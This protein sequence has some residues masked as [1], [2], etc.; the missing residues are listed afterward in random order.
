MPINAPMSDSAIDEMFASIGRAKENVARGME[1][2]RIRQR[3]EARRRR[4]SGKEDI[5]DDADLDEMERRIDEELR[6]HQ[7]NLKHGK[8]SAITAAAT[9]SAGFD[10]VPDDIINDAAKVSSEVMGKGEELAK[11][12]EQDVSVEDIEAM[13][14]AEV[15][16][17]VHD[18][19]SNKRQPE[20]EGEEEK[21]DE[22]ATRPEEPVFDVELVEDEPTPKGEPEKESKMKQAEKAE[23]DDTIAVEFDDADEGAEVKDKESVA[24]EAKGYLL[25][26]ANGGM[27]GYAY[28]LTVDDSLS[29]NALHSQAVGN[30]GWGDA[31]VVGAAELLAMCKKRGIPKISVYAKKSSCRLLKNIIDGN[32]QTG[33]VEV[34]RA[35][36]DKVF[37]LAREIRMELYYQDDGFDSYKRDF[38]SMAAQFITKK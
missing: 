23:E 11:E 17:A 4:S 32:G 13:T 5:S 8:G 6:E 16:D 31:I 15:N 28:M 25:A 10:N 14:E 9:P 21:K 36:A 2:D 1:E 7:N 26:A 20:P 30:V 27:A 37:E 19:A 12:T 3:E 34:D 22:L 29:E 18:M 24:Q 35:N 38:T 33:K